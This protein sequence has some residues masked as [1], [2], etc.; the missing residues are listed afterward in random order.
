MTVSMSRQVG[1]RCGSSI[2]EKGC[3]R[4][5]LAS[6]AWSFEESIDGVSPPYL[7]THQTCVSRRRGGVRPI[8]GMNVG[9]SVGVS[10]V[11]VLSMT[12][13]GKSVSGGPID[14]FGAGY[15]YL[16]Q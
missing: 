13:G 11:R 5:S 6:S 14:V 16:G 3:K 4:A 8:F 9:V 10:P 1:W 2:N 12:D 15:L 7:L